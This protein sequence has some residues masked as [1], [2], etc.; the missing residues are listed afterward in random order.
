MKASEKSSSSAS[1]SKSCLKLSQNVKNTIK[2]IQQ[3]FYVLGSSEQLNEITLK[4]D[5]IIILDETE[6]Q[7][8]DQFVEV[9]NVDEVDTKDKT[10][11]TPGIFYVLW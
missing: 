8:D 7:I 3:F 11:S 5:E 10:N 9:S 4:E 2:I 6:I 1:S